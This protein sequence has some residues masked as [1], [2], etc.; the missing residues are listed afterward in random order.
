MKVCRIVLFSS[1]EMDDPFPT[2]FFTP[3]HHYFPILRGPH[4]GI[5]ICV[6]GVGQGRVYVFPYA[7]D[8]LST[9][10]SN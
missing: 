9:L 8:Q 4:S 5:Q 7:A 1:A 10:R 6:F 3:L 2:T